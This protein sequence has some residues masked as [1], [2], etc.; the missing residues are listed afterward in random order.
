LSVHY[1][2][3]LA[4][5]RARLPEY[6]KYRDC[7]GEIQIRSVL[8]HAW[9]EI[10]HD[11][12]YKSGS[13]VP[14]EAI[15]QFSRIAGLLEVA[16]EGFVALRQRLTDY[17]VVVSEKIQGDSNDLL[18][19][20][21]SFSALIS[22]DKNIRKID[23]YVAAETGIPIKEEVES[24]DVTDCADYAPDVSGRSLCSY[25]ACLTPPGLSSLPIVTV[26]RVRHLEYQS[27]AQ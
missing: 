7:V 1:I 16:D 5:A 13:A 6:S 17:E 11:L 8:Q 12:G 18:I 21:V 27:G 10:E 24:L 2:V 20:V 3:S 19:D 25:L 23:E 9:A 4:P 22:S 14:R 26:V 15:R